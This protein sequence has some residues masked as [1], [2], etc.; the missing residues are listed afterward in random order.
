MSEPLDLLVTWGQGETARREGDRF[1]GDAP[2][3]EARLESVAEVPVPVSQPEAFQWT[4]ERDRALERA[5]ARQGSLAEVKVVR[6]FRE[7]VQSGR[8]EQACARVEQELAYWKSWPPVGEPS[9]FNEAVFALCN[10][11]S[12]CLEAS[13]VADQP[14]LFQGLLEEAERSLLRGRQWMLDARPR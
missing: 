11:L 12:L 1:E 7:A 3:E 10:G 4:A 6:E 14:A 5:L 13:E 9:R 2:A 8:L